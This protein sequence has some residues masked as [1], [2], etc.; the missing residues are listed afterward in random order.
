[1]DHRG[2]KLPSS[3]DFVRKM[4]TMLDEESTAVAKARSKEEQ[5][6]NKHAGNEEEQEEEEMD[7]T[8]ARRQARHFETEA[9]DLADD[10]VHPEYERLLTILCDPYLLHI[11]MP[12]LESWQMLF[13]VK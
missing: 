9:R 10:A 3:V 5:L 12:Q 8:E 13:N 6:A 1:M 4:Q 7:I 2:G 11:V